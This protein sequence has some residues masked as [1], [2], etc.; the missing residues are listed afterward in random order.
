M[1]E[2]LESP[3]PLPPP[4]ASSLHGPR[5]T[6][7]LRGVH[8]SL[9]LS[10]LL[11]ELH[12]AKVHDAPSQ[13]IHADLLL[14]AEAQHVKGYLQGHREKKAKKLLAPCSTEWRPPWGGTYGLLRHAVDSGGQ[15]H[16][17]QRERGLFSSKESRPDAP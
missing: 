10:G 14:G 2:A 11:L 1:Q 8:F 13:L 17:D 7:T 9:L 4:A 6:P 16:P 5:P 15:T 12:V 3:E